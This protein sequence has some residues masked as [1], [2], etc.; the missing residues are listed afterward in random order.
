MGRRAVKVGRG[1]SEK[2]LRLH[3]TKKEELAER[4]GDQERKRMERT[5]NV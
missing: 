3:Q 2:E 5:K 4:W 1:V